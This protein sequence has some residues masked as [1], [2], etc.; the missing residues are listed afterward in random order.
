MSASSDISE[1]GSDLARIR[2]EAMGSYVDG[3]NVA[4]I[5]LSN[6][7]RSSVANVGSDNFGPSLVAALMAT[8][9]SEATLFAGSTVKHSK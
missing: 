3:S 7:V 1:I 5:V 6:L 9:A 4:D 2:S 8:T